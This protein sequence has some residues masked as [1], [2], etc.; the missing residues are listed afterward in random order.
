LR[1]PLIKRSPR[2]L[3]WRATACLGLLAPVLAFSSGTAAADG[4]AG[5]YYGSDS[6]GPSAQGGFPY[7]E[8]GTGGLYGS[9]TAEVG[10]WT[11]WRGCTRGV[12]VDWTDVDA[13]NADE[14]A[15]PAI[16][17]LSLYWFMAGPGAD[18]RYDG[19]VT[20]AYAWGRAQAQAANVDYYD[21]GLRSE[22]RHTPMMYMDVE[23]QPTA[24]YANGWNEI[25][26]SC[27]RITHARIVPVQ[28]DR[29]TFNGFWDWI[30]RQTIFHP[31]VYST[32]DYWEETFGFGPAAAI[33][34]TYEWTAESSTQQTTPQPVG[35][36]QHGRYAEWFGGVSASHETGWQ[37]TE[38]GGD[39]D[40]IDA[41]HLP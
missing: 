6:N 22:S 19:G 11:N 29:A 23:G 16:P 24:G 36:G 38:K 1:P 33:P 15:N 28:V 31:G 4:P 20:E 5:F 14:R 13:V 8:P 34:N 18:P 12:A 30:H 2:T 10:T 3:G 37:W 35:F 17:G 7:H 9:Y 32:P 27:G 21:L 40:Q 25:V 26:N 39:W 41:A